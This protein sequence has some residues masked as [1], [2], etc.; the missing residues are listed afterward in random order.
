MYKVAIFSSD[1]QFAQKISRSINFL[2]CNIFR[3]P[4]ILSNYRAEFLQNFDLIFVHKKEISLEVNGFFFEKNSS[5]LAPACAVAFFPDSQSQLAGPLLDMGFDRCLNE[6]FDE[7]HLAALVRALLRR[8]LGLCSTVSFYGDLEF[9]HSTKLSLLKSTAL[10]LPLREAQ[11]LGLLLRKVGKIVPTEEFL[12]EIDP[13]STRMNKSTIHAYIHRLR[14][15]I[16]SN[17]L[18]IRNIKRNGYFLNKHIQNVHLKEVNTV[19]GNLY[20]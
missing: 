16:S 4:I 7:A 12:A 3:F 2:D 19:F 8:G 9:N 1:D 5:H 17:I 14:N 10:Q 11:I 13:L 6:S 15:R 20:R 18:P